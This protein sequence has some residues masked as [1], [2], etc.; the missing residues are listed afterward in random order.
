MS[1][2]GAAAQVFGVGDVS[3]VKVVDVIEPMSP[4]VLYVDKTR[5]DFDPHLD[6]LQP[7]FIDENRSMLLSIHSLIVQTGRHTVLIDTCLGND[8]E[9][10]G[11]PQWNHRRGTFLEDLAR[12][13]CPPESIDYV[14]CT[15]M[16]IDHTGWNTSLVDGRWVPT[17]PNARY[18]FNRKEWEGIKDLP[19]VHEQ[20]VLRQNL[21]PIVEAEQVQ[22]VDGEWE[23]DDVVRLLPTPGHTPGHC[24][25]AVSSGAGRAVITGDMMIHP[26][27]I[28]EPQWQQ[29]ADADKAL[30]AATRTAFVQEHCDT[31]VLVLGTHFNTPT[32][33]HIVSQGDRTRIRL[34]S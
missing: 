10:A 8:K 24:S 27:Q 31:D 5:E 19:G 14:F 34:T 12:A 16:H 30:A 1:G 23:I 33:V 20:A 21:L 4:K 2:S 3:I 25:V 17:F 18:L 29:A 9:S 26:V 32:G 22:W 7:Q 15:H 28:A 13:G 11:F 6:W